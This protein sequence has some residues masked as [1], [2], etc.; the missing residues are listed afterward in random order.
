MPTYSNPR[1]TAVINDWP[2]GRHRT[3]ATFAIETDPRRGQ[4]GTR[5]TVDPKTGRASAPKTLTYGHSTRIVAG[6]DGRT[7][8]LVLCAGQSHITVFQS[9]MQYQEETI[10]PR[11][12]RYADLLA[13]LSA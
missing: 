5:T 6:N 1:M 3:T 8:I 11:D 10:F 2:Y 12:T 4:R 13:L 7:Y 9:N